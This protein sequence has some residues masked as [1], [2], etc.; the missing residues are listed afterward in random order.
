[1]VNVQ[2][3]KSYAAN[4]PNNHKPYEA[5]ES[6]IEAH[7]GAITGLGAL[8]ELVA[9]ALLVVQGCGEGTEWGMREAR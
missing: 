9:H 6:H 4:A 7:F 2:L 1:M 8:E 5:A 3:S